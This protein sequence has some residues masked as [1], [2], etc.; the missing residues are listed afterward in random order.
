[1][2]IAR[3]FVRALQAIILSD[4][5]GLSECQA[6]PPAIALPEFFSG[7]EFVE[8]NFALDRLR[9]ASAVVKKERVAVGTEHIGNIQGCRIIE[10][11]LHSSADAVVVIFGFNDRE[12]DARFVGKDVVGAFWFATGG[13]LAA[14]D[15]APF[16]E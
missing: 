8:A 9:L 1:L 11:L 15:D 4:D 2:I 10:C 12:L 13:K 3:R 16:G 5:G 7:R 6:F 14:N